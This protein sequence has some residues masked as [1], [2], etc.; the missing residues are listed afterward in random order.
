MQGYHVAG[1][2]SITNRWHVLVAEARDLADVV[3]A[4]TALAA[5][6]QD[7]FPRLLPGAQGLNL[8]AQYS[9]GFAYLADVGGPPL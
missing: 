3:M 5:P 6:D 9:C 8:H 1:D 7:Q 2:A 4:D